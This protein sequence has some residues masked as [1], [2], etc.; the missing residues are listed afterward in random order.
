MTRTCKRFDIIACNYYLICTLRCNK[1]T[2]MKFFLLILFSAITGILLV[3]RDVNKSN[4]TVNKIIAEKRSAII[5]CRPDL[6]AID[7]TDSSNTISLLDGWGKYRMKVT[8]GNKEADTYFQQGINMYYGFHIIEA[9]A[10]FERAIQ[11]DNQFAMAYWGKA[12]AY[13][14]N[15]NDLGYS[16]SPDALASVKKAMELSSSCNSVEK[17]LIKA[18]NVRYT[19]DTTQ[20]REYLNQL[21]ADA[22]KKVHIQFPNSADAAALY[23]DA[24]MIQHPWDLYDNH[25]NPQPWTPEIVKVLEKLVVQFPNNPGASHY[26]IHA[27]EGSKNPAKALAVAN[28]LG[29]M[30]PGVAHLVHMP[31]HIYIR[32]GLYKKG[33]ESNTNAI[34]GYNDYVSKYQPAANGVFLYLLHNVHMQAACAMMGGQYKKAI[35][36]SAE[37]KKNIDNPT[38]ESDGY[39]GTYSQYIYSSNI[40]AEI[41]FG[42]WDKILN[43]PVVEDNHVYQNILLQFAKGIA[44]ARTGKLNEA[45]TALQ[46][47][48]KLKINPQLAD[49][50]A[51][52]NPAITGVE[53]AVKILQGAIAEEKKDYKAAIAYLQE[54]VKDEDN[55]LYNEPRDWL[56][57][58]RQYLGS[59]LL[60]A[61]KNQE[62]EKI[63]REDLKINPANQ[64]SLTGLLQALQKQKKTA[65]ANEIERQLDKASAAADIKIDKTVF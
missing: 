15:I 9:I 49:H 29:T 30:M 18:M 22:M 13:G 20:T 63:F 37:L 17:A 35:E 1:T 50:P 51:A 62:A 65:A 4:L 60:K 19:N 21:Y 11:I 34:N 48:Q 43:M 54:A 61:A 26:Y 14:P 56:L 45:N 12:L 16:A 58:A 59:V 33:I 23:A 5:S 40:M 36:F 27:V 39:M 31:S 47:I 55:M 24:L 6:S 10:S 38:L 28:R 7:F 57:P 53:L 25:S 3:N 44:C 41:R 64:W 52:F 32:T 46:Y 42:K 2:T 8:A